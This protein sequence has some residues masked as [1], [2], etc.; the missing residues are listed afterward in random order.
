MCV[1][2]CVCV[3]VRVC[4]CV[5]VCV[6]MCVCVRVRVCVS[7]SV[8]VCTCVCVCV[9][10]YYSVYYDYDSTFTSNHDKGYNCWN[11]ANSVRSLTPTS[12]HTRTFPPTGSNYSIPIRLANGSRVGEGRVEINY[13]G[14]WGTICDIFWGIQDA[15]VVCRQLGYSGT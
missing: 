6:C 14:N 3:C 13:N 8:C 10:M 2:V 12:T 1:S 9:H 15:N 11:T 4:V 7:V 5:C